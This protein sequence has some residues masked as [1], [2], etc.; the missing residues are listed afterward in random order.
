M[1]GIKPH[2]IAKGFFLSIP[3]TF[4]EEEFHHWKDMMKMYVKFPHY[5]LWKII[6][7]GDIEIYF[8]EEE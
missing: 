3:P 1:V 8:L 2:L 6:T 7:H 4:L 5:Q